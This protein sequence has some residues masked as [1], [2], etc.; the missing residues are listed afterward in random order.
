LSG[1]TDPRQL[2]TDGF[3]KDY[4]VSRK[5]THDDTIKSVS[6]VNRI[7]GNMALGYFPAT[8]AVAGYAGSYIFR[9]ALSYIH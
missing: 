4:E 8:A 1:G 6:R 7:L 2:F 3:F 5:F 9:A